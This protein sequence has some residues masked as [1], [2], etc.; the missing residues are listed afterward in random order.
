MADEKKTKKTFIEDDFEGGADGEEEEI[1][2]STETKRRHP[3]WVFSPSRDYGVRYVLKDKGWYSYRPETDEWIPQGGV[4]AVR[5]YLTKLGLNPRRD[6][7]EDMSE[8]TL[9]IQYVE[10]NYFVDFVGNYSGYLKSGP[11]TLPS[12][13]SILVPRGRALPKVEKGDWSLIKNFITGLFRDRRQRLAFFGWLAVGVRTLREDAPGDWTP[14]QALVLLG[15]SGVGKSTLQI[16]ITACLTGRFAD[17]TSYFLGTTNFSGEMALAEHWAMSDPEW[18]DAK[19]KQRLAKGYK[20]AVA[21]A[22]TATEA[23]YQQT[24]NIPLFKRVTTSI[25][26]DED[27][28]ILPLM[29]RS[30]LEKLMMLDCCKSKYMPTAKNWKNWRAAALA[31]VPAFLSGC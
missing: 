10:M 12:G 14:G 24:I 16:L 18:E 29:D 9:V 1:S 23:K 6:E 31:E 20:K 28:Q 2:A 27:F 26:D 17:P 7:D 25:N 19:Q 22:N 8:V 21:D 15:D 4:E 11:I 30:Y 3:V 13:D 5:R